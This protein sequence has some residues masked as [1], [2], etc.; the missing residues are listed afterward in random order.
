MLIKSETTLALRCPECGKLEY[1]HLS[2]FAFSGV[3]AVQVKC[4]CG[5]VKLVITHKTRHRFKL[6][7]ACVLCEGNHTR[8]Y[9]AEKLWSGEVISLQCMDTGYDLGYIGA[10]RQVRELAENVEDELEE[11]LDEFGYDDY[12][13]NPDIMGQVMHYLRDIVEKDNLY[14]QCGNHQIDVDIFPD[15]LELHC[16]ECDSINIIYAET[17]DDLKVIQQVDYIELAQHGFKCLDSLSNTKKTK[18][19]RRRRKKQQ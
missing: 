13:A 7:V 1:H 11:L 17:E 14:C 6:Q 18:K 5:A 12:F 8:E 16:K 2:R 15:R 10:D 4:S 3:T 19:T 9:S